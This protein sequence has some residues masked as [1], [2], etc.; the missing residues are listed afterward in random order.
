M[1]GKNFSAS[2]KDWSDKVKRMTDEIVQESVRLLLA[3]LVRNMPVDTGNLVRSVKVTLNGVVPVDR[4]PD[5]TYTDPS[6]GNAATLLRVKA[7]QPV[8]ISIRAPYARRVNYGRSS[9][10]SAGRFFNQAGAFFFE[11]TASKW[12]VIVDQAVANVKA[13]G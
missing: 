8:Y 7:G 6:A 4:D 12:Q 2:V 3:E 13:R 11:V 10:D 1:S 5:K 9:A